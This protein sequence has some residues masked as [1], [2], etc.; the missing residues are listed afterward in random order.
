M[1]NVVAASYF[2]EGGVQASNN[3]MPVRRNLNREPVLEKSKLAHYFLNEG[4][5]CY[6]LL[7]VVIFS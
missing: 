5:L 3:A 2:I 1:L 4:L 7:M 6:L